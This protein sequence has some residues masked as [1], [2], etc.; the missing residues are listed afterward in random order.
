[1]NSPTISTFAEPNT[2][3]PFDKVIE[4]VLP[5]IFEPIIFESEGISIKIFWVEPAPERAREFAE[6]TILLTV[7][8]ATSVSLERL[9]ESN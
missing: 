2:L 3:F 7:D 9:E 6:L 1:M 5:N 4:T 8:F